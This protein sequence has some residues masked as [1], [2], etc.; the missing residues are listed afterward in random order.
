MSPYFDV[1][2]GRDHGRFCW[3]SDDVLHTKGRVRG[4]RRHVVM[5]CE[6]W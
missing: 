5:G 4:G 1:S 2:R 3:P 6:A